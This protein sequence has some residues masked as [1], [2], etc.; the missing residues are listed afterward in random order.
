MQTGQR[1]TSSVSS[2]MGTVIPAAD[3]LAT[4]DAAPEKKHQ[5]QTPRA[6]LHSLPRL[7]DAYTN[8]THQNFW[9]YCHI[10]MSYTQQTGNNNSNDDDYDDDNAN[11]NYNNNNSNNSNDDDD[12]DDV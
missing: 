10:L 12:D 2:A 6:Q 3:W 4:L 5:K 1:Q 8:G 7:K 11:H 9:T